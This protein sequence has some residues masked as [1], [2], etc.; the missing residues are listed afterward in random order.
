MSG[1][2]H[3]EEVDFQHISNPA[4]ELFRC[5]F[6]KERGTTGFSAMEFEENIP[7]E[8]FE[9]LRPVLMNMLRSYYE[10]MMLSKDMFDWV[11]TSGD[12]SYTNMINLDYL[13]KEHIKNIS[14]DKN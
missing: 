8:L 3:V 4:I 13:V 6:K 14:E 7:S 12:E 10:G 5:K 11:S 1:T 9:A 2:L